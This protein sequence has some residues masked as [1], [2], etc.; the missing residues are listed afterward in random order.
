[1]GSSWPAKQ[2]MECNICQIE[3]KSRRR[4]HEEGEI[5]GL[6]SKWAF[7]PRAVPNNDVRYELNKLQAR[8]FAQKHNLQ[9][10]WSPAKDKVGM[11][12]LRSDPGLPGKKSNGLE[13]MTANVATSMVCFQ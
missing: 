3:R 5:D 12:A 11:E 6:E 10:L 8:R 4:A 9:L 1:M 7:A 2:R 13:G